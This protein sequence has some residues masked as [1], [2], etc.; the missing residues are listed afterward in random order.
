MKPQSSP[1]P[2]PS[3]HVARKQHFKTAQK[4]W[5]LHSSLLQEGRVRAQRPFIPECRTTRGLRMHYVFLYARRYA[6][7]NS[8]GT[9]IYAEVEDG[10]QVLE[11][12]Q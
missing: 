12:I 11:G 3:S 7:C 5:D 8:K 4:L 6:R 1:D 2:L 9:G 10:I